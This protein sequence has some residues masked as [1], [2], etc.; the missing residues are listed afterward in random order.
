MIEMKELARMFRSVP[1][2]IAILVGLVSPPIAMIAMMVIYFDDNS[3]GESD[4]GESD[5][6]D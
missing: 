3:G 2:P 4:A 1:W 6:D 5:S